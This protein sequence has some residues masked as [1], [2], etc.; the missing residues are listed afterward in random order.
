MIA[1]PFEFMNSLSGVDDGLKHLVLCHPLRKSIL[2]IR[3]RKHPP[4][5]HFYANQRARMLFASSNVSGQVNVGGK[6]YGLPSIP[7]AD[8]EID[9]LERNIADLRTAGKI[10]CT[11]DFKYDVTYNEMVD[12]LQFGEYDIIHYSGHGFFSD[13]PEN[14]CLFFWETPGG[15]RVTNRIATLSATELNTLVERTKTRFIYLSCCQG[16]TAGGVEHLLSNDFLG[17]SHSLVVA[18]IPAVL[19]MR[20][21]LSDEMAVLLATSLYRELFQGHSLELSLFR[22]RRRLQAKNPNDYNWLSPMLIVQGE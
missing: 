5:I 20:W 7:G 13:S 9:T 18:G 2:G 19:A 12:L 10:A 3:T 8:Q 15:A 21:P 6:L 11:A 22:A 16:G 4:A 1:F 14:S 17:I